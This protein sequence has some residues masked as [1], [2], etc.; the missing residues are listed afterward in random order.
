MSV[1]NFKVISA[2]FFELSCDKERIDFL[3][4]ILIPFFIY[5]WLFVSANWKGM[6]QLQKIS[7][8]QK[9]EKKTG[10][11]KIS[12]LKT[13]TSQ[14]KSYFKNLLEKNSMPKKGNCLYLTWALL[15]FFSSQHSFSWNI[16][17]NVIFFAGGILFG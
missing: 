2:T 17:R 11:F 8:F 15:D 14:K 13:I 5:Y 1:Q 12:A 4:C 6:Y 16:F 7:R 3:D 9:C 10:T